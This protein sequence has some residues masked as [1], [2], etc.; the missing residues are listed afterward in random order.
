MTLT[1]AKAALWPHVDRRQHVPPLMTECAGLVSA[2]D[3]VAP[4]TVLLGVNRQRV[5]ACR[6]CLA[7]IKTLVQVLPERR[8][9]R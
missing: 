7:V 4:Q 9:V 3:N 6:G 1:E 5:T 8:A 2:H